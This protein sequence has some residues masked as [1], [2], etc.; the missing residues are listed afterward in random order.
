MP[1]D[2]NS[3]PQSTE[4][5][6]RLHLL[7]HEIRTSESDYSYV[8]DV[9]TFE[10]HLN[11]YK[12]LR[13]SGSVWPELTFDDG[14]ISNLELAAPLLQA[15]AMKALFFITVGWTGTKRDY[16]NWEE[17]RALHALG[18]P[19]GAHGWSHTL[20]THCSD[21]ELQNELGRARL[22]LEDKLGSSITAMSLPGGRAN[23]RVLAACK[24]A[25]YEHVYTSEPKVEM[26][27]YSFT[28]GRL[29]ILGSMQIDWLARLFEPHSTLLASL[30]RKHRIKATA[31]NLLGDRLYEKL[32][33]RLNRSE[34]DPAE[35]REAT[36]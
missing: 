2:F 21:A 19:I 26:P 4:P 6:Q 1:A 22:T 7:Y 28:I 27:P 24:T 34:V 9:A 17:L 5:A 31:K 13:A 30:Q 15:H 16:M 32:W 23:A 14:H 35:E 36:E 29:N 10:Q 33:A 8:T 3:N 18:Q 25:G 11:L 12:R 20:L